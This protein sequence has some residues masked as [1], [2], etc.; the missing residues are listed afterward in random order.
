MLIFELKSCI[1]DTEK[2]KGGNTKKKGNLVL[3]TVFSLLNEGTHLEDIP[4][5]LVFKK[6]GVGRD[7]K[8]LGLA[9]PGNPS[10]S[11]D[12]DLVA[13]WKTIKENRF[14]NYEAYFTILNTGKEAISKEWLIDLIYN[15]DNSMDKAPAVWKNFIKNISH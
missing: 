7:I 15:H 1:I 6:T 13:F 5:F 11:P 3:E 9:A 12:K 4:P 2:E 8:F 14:Q 10:I